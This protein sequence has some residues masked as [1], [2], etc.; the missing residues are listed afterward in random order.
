M[1]VVGRSAALGLDEQRPARAH[2]AQRVVQAGRRGDQLAL[3]GA[4][5]VRPAKPRRALETAVLVQD[6][7]RRDQP[8]PGQPV[9]QQRGP[10]AVFGKV[11]HGGVPS[12]VQQRAVLDVPGKHGH[13]LRIDTRTPDRQRVADDPEHHARNPQLQAQPDGGGQRAVGNRHGA[14][15]TAHQDRLGQ[16]AMQR[17]LEPGRE[18]VRPAH[19]TAPPEK[20][21]KDRKKLEAAKAMLKPNTIWISLRKPPDVSPKASARPVAMMM[22]TATM[23]ATGP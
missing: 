12:H 2:P 23:R 10:L 7:A 20:L 3:R 15:C 4:V 21:K 1:W 22:M 8:G 18:G 13:E 6:D 17:H 14:R 11:Q 9:G 5:E 16:R 19:T